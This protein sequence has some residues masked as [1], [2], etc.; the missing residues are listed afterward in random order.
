MRREYAIDKLI[1]NAD[2]CA[3]MYELCQKL[4]IEMLVAKIIK[5]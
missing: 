2:K 3:N 4:G 1:E 5:K